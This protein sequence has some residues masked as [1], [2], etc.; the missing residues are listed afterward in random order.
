MRSGQWASHVIFSSAPEKVI[1]AL[2]DENHKGRVLAMFRHPVDRLVS[3][4]FYLQIATWE[5]PKRLE[6][7]GSLSL[8]AT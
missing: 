8:G 6:G 1:T 3:K 2:F 4:F 5:G 7:D